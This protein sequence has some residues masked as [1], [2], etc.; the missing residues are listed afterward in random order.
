MST[1]P[2][3]TS[4]P[5]SPPAHPVAN[6]PATPRCL[7]L[8][9]ASHPK[10][11]GG[12]TT[13][14]SLAG[15]GT[16]VA[17]ID[18]QAGVP[19]PR[20]GKDATLGHR[21]DP[22][23]AISPA[24]TPD[25][26]PVPDGANANSTACPIPQ[27]EQ[28]ASPSPRPHLRLRPR[29]RH[30]TQ[31][32]APASPLPIRRPPPEFFHPLVEARP[33][34]TASVRPDTKI[35]HPKPIAHP[36][37]LN[38]N[39]PDSLIRSGSAA[40]N[41]AQLEATAERLSMTSSIDDAIRELHLELKRS[42]SRRSARLALSRMASVDELVASP[43]APIGPH[44]S[45]A[46]SLVPANSAAR[47]RGYSPAACFA[48]SPSVSLTGP[49]RCG[50]IH[51]A[52]RPDATFDSMLARNPS[53][54]SSIRSFRS[55]KPSLAE[56]SESEPVSLDKKA[57]DEADAAPPL[58]DLAD[59]G[60]QQQLSDTAADFV[61]STDAFHQMLQDGLGSSAGPQQGSKATTAAANTTA[62]RR[63]Q[64]QQRR[65]ESV[66]SSNTSEQARDAFVDFDGVHWEPQDEADSYVPQALESDVLAQRPMLVSTAQPTQRTSYIDPSTGQ[67]MLYYPARVPAML[68]LPPK[69]STKPK[70]ASRNDRRS[71][72]LSTMMDM[73]AAPCMQDST[74][75]KR[76]S[77]LADFGATFPADPPVRDSWLP[78]PIASHR[79]SFAALSS[80]GALD[81]AA[82]Q[83]VGVANHVTTRQDAAPRRPERLSKLP[84]DNRKSV[85]SMLGNLPAQL[86]ASAFFDLPSI[87]PEVEI[88]D[89]SAMATL[90]SILDASASAP[91][92]AFTDHL[93]VG[94]LGPEVYGKQNQKGGG[95]SAA[96]GQ[97]RAQPKKMSS[98]VRLG[99]KRGSSSSSS[100]SNG[101]DKPARPHSSIA[102]TST[103]LYGV[104]HRGDGQLTPDSAD[105]AERVIRLGAGREGVPGRLD[106]GAELEEQQEEEDDQPFEARYQGPPTTLLAELMMRKQEQRQRVRNLGK[107]LPNGNYATLLDLDT[108]A[109]VQMRNRKNKRV[110]LAW[111]HVDALDDQNGSDDEDVP[112]AIVAAMQRGAKNLA[113]LDRP[114]GLMERRERE[115]NEPLSHRRA[116]LQGMEPPTPA[117]A[118]PARQSMMSFPAAHALQLLSPNAAAGVGVSVGPEEPEGGA[119]EEV[120]G[121]TLGERRRRLATKDGAEVLPTARR[122]S[123]SFSAELLNQFGD[124]EDGRDGSSTSNNNKEAGAAK[125]QSAA[126]AAV[127]AASKTPCEEETLGQRRRRLQAE[128]QGRER[129]MSHGNPT[130]TTT[131]AAAAAVAGT[132]SDPPGAR[133]LSLA[134]VLSAHPTREGNT[135]AREEQ[136]R[137]ELEMRAAQERESKMSAMRIQ[138]PTCLPQS[139]RDRSGGFLGGAFNDGTGGQ[140]P[141]AAMNM[142]SSALSP[143]NRASVMTGYGVPNLGVVTSQSAFGAGLNGFGGPG[144]AG[145]S[146]ISMYN[147]AASQM[148]GGM[149]P[150]QAKPMDR[151]EQWRY[152]VRP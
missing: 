103:A 85:A 10:S 116:R 45:T 138:M 13:P 131:T 7:S 43:P 58:E 11:R 23:A 99:R 106:Q 65:P 89:G 60:M 146:S 80:F 19:G 91:V 6:P 57:F 31:D 127:P 50:S 74:Q 144:G 115:D 21:Q 114:V 109:E 37:A 101:D 117:A 25:L 62:T 125:K 5:C 24:K 112:L 51:S 92:S 118:L 32:Q 70:A 113:D 34:R 41:I 104:A 130:T 71:Q 59:E 29:A 1:S 35:V 69:L 44:F 40:G 15:A 143:G 151:V 98:M 94:K 39:L 20:P 102:L 61:P 78:D 22:F 73:T 54:K 133:R 48:M 150:A 122:V 16:H 33:L 72:I 12:G 123:L 84:K 147:D 111:E 97:P 108:V 14:S 139:N 129:E 46:A 64:Q 126:A 88:K 86:R 152:S 83:P 27:P 128:R 148:Y 63:R 77:V 93:Y 119:M 134:N 107:G 49:L 42:D 18:A 100:S 9:A 120:E 105:S 68:N 132:W 124:P 30:C 8:D 81:E 90:D 121:E 135:R 4:S 96:T 137:S 82:Q 149:K 76:Q 53:G 47:H 141:R 95:K 79:D 110:N 56:I 36:P 87:S 67:N 136:V 52:G 38:H 145:K 142:S 55:S 66:H 75:R 17:A 28:E 140:G 3:A 26:P 2:P